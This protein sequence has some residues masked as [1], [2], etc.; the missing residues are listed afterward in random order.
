MYPNFPYGSTA[1]VYR[2]K[3]VMYSLIYR[4]VVLNT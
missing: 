1:T 2:N 4:V 3:Y